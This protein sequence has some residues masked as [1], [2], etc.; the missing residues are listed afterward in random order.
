MKLQLIKEKT[1]RSYALKNAGSKISFEDWLSKV[2]RA[3]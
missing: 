2:K 3:D 1:I